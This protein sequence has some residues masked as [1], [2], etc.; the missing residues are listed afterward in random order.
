MLVIR[1][2]AQSRDGGAILVLE[3][4]PRHELWRTPDPLQT[5]WVCSHCGYPLE[6]D[7]VGVDLLYVAHC[8]GQCLLAGAGALGYQSLLSSIVGC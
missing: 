2:S 8:K 6:C 4:L 5:T 3:E 1:S 7:S